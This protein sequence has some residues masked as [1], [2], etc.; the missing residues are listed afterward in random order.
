MI[1]SAMEE[2][3]TCS[4]LAAENRRAHNE[5]GHRRLGSSGQLRH[6]WRDLTPPNLFTSI[7]ASRIRRL[8]AGSPPRNQPRPIVVE[9]AVSVVDR[10]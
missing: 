2:P 7:L 4:S 9:V 10:C 6:E 5:R 3:H 8:I 1:A